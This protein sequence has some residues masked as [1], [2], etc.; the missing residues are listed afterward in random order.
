[1][2]KI[3]AKRQKNFDTP[4][5]KRWW[6]CLNLFLM[7]WWWSTIQHS[8]LNIYLFLVFFLFYLLS[9]S[10]FLQC[11]FLLYITMRDWNKTHKTE[12][13]KRRSNKNYLFICE[14]NDREMKWQWTFVLTLKCDIV[15][16][17]YF[18]IW[19]LSSGTCRMGRKNV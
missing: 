14:R 12:S 7:Q 15:G 19:F 5:H 17:K 9:N 16:C 4:S 2:F 11:E 3:N 1:M 13:K 18:L 10:S 6:P 8:L